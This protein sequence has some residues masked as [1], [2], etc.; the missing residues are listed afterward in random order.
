MNKTR[1]KVAWLLYNQADKVGDLAHILH[2]LE[3]RVWLRILHLL[4]RPSNAVQGVNALI[5]WLGDII[6]D[7]CPKCECSPECTC[8]RERVITVCKCDYFCRCPPGESCPCLD[9]CVCQPRTVVM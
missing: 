1:I 4:P 3:K 8:P 9:G 6:D 2:S 7:P 5:C